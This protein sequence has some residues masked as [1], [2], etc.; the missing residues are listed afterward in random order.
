[1]PTVGATLFFASHPQSPLLCRTLEPRYLKSPTFVTSSR[2]ILTVPFLILFL[3]QTHVFRMYPI[4]FRSSSLQ[5]IS[6][7][8]Q[9]LFF[10]FLALAT[11]HN[12]ISEHHGPRTILSDLIRHYIHHHCKQT[13]LKADYW[14][15]SH[16]HLGPLLY[17]F[18][19]PSPT[20]VLL[21]RPRL[22]LEIPHL[23]RRKQTR[24]RTN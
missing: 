9:L 21:C 5:C 7:T 15:S 1:M 11:Y 17:S 23:F 16:L 2:C 8:I 13:G 19:A 12:V 24:T 20:V 6:P 10:L 3:I 14:C 22:S 18:R 4:D